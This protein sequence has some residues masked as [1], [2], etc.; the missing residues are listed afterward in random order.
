MTLEGETF[1]PR[2]LLYA[3]KA[4]I[5][6]V[7][8]E[9]RADGLVLTKSVAFNIGLANLGLARFQSRAALDRRRAAPGSLAL[10]MVRDLAIK[11]P[12]ASKPRSA[13]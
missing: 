10:A 3:V 4:G 11:T 7:P 12:E 5:G 6:F 2:R 8:E 13:S 9:R 1:A